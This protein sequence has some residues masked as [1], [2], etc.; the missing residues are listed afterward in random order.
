MAHLT[1]LETKEHALSTLGEFV[2]ERRQQLGL[3]QEELAARVGDGIRQAEISRLEHDRVSLPRR[4]RLEALATALEIPLA[5]LFIRTGWLDEV[6]RDAV[7][8]EPVET[9]GDPATIEA[10]VETVTNLHEVLF[11]ASDTLAQVEAAV[12][13]LVEG[14]R[15]RS[16]GS[17]LERA[18]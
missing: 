7:G 6:H 3:T 5:D 8:T 17:T 15:M 4:E 9:R 11:T 2:R 14:E 13:D 16:L 1:R 18:K 10:L 12:A